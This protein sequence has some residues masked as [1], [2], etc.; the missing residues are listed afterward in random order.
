MY[1]SLTQKLINRKL[2]LL[3]LNMQNVFTE[4]HFSLVTS[5]V[6][7]NRNIWI[8]LLEFLSSWKLNYR[9]THFFQRSCNRS[10]FSF[11]SRGYRLAIEMIESV[12]EW[13][14]KNLSAIDCMINCCC[15]IVCAF[16]I[17]KDL[18]NIF[19]S[20]IKLFWLQCR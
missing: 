8:W 19:S 7:S 1:P 16:N 6:P 17:F 13:C 2:L 9:S 4:T 14:T 18:I 20:Y 10:L 12:W 11:A 15:N 3:F 5:N